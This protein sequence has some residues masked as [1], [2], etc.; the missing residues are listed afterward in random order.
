MDELKKLPSSTVS[1][2]EQFP[3]SPAPRAPVPRRPPPK[4]RSDGEQPYKRT[5]PD[6]VQK[7]L[8]FIVLHCATHGLDNLRNVNDLYGIPSVKAIIDRDELSEEV[9]NGIY[10]RLVDPVKYRL[11]DKIKEWA[12]NHV[13]CYMRGQV[14][15]ILQTEGDLWVLGGIGDPLH[16]FVP[17]GQNGVMDA[18]I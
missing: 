1:T 15:R 5:S 4:R 12:A 14:Y 11:E 8:E 13:Y 9:V 10:C 6:L 18:P 3:K 7:K 2:K 16:R 17:I